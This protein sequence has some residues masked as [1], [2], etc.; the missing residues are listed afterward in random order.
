VVLLY[1]DLVKQA[2]HKAYL[3]DLWRHLLAA[4]REQM[5]SA[6]TKG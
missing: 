5:L 3:V 1:K 4:G 6:T 2:D